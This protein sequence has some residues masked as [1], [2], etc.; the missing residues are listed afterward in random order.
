[1]ENGRKIITAFIE[2]L[3]LVK[4]IPIALIVVSLIRIV[5]SSLRDPHPGPLIAKYSSL[6]L[7]FHAFFGTEASAIRSQHLKYN[8]SVIRVAPK[9]LSVS[10]RNNDLS[11]EDPVIQIYGHKGGLPKPSFYSNFDLD[12]HATLFS[13]QDDEYRTRRTKAVNFLFALSRVRDSFE[14]DGEACNVLVKKF[15]E[16]LKRHI[17][18]SQKHRQLKS[19]DLVDECRRLAIDVVT[20]HLYGHA[21][22]ALEEDSL[23]SDSRNSQNQDVENFGPGS[24]TASGFVDSCVMIGRFYLLPPRV[25]A[26]ANT[27]IEWAFPSKSI[28]QSC[29][30]VNRYCQGCIEL[31]RAGEETYQ[32][33]LLFDVGIS[34]QEAQA[35]LKDL[36][37]AGTDTTAL[38]LATLFFHLIRRRDW[39]LKLKDEVL[40][41]SSSEEALLDATIKEGL[42]LGLGTPTRLPRVVSSRTD[43]VKVLGHHMPVG[44][45]LG[46]S[47]FCLHTDP[48][49]FP[50]PFDFYPERWL[51][52]AHEDSTLSRMNANMM[53][54]G[55]GK[56]KC[57]AQN[58]ARQELL[59]ATKAVVRSGVL[60][61]MRTIRDK[62]DK[63]EWFNSKVSGEGR[64]EVWLPADRM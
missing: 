7:H 37:F 47:S 36:I 35:Q 48:R 40:N 59:S 27:I 16:R 13:T 52:A 20:G 9:H 31:A 50:S 64:V 38:N 1:M 58:I 51:E 12:G 22:G 2:P 30:K 17:D 54:F 6:W 14:V 39:L 49:Y 32:S 46:C 57:I 15:V 26:V 53:P 8:S 18:R 11:D 19:I 60:E 25:F 42:R 21:Y 56:R 5:R 62:V 10:N 23:L 4:I 63:V 29:G 43:N 24:M 41:D 34:N 44:T 3:S 33:R 55:A 28:D 61:G 45:I